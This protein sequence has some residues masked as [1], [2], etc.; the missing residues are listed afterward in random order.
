MGSG[1]DAILAELREH[2][3]AMWADEMASSKGR[4]DSIASLVRYGILRRTYVGIPGRC[5]PRVRLELIE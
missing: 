5:T 4:S 1:Q 3:R 2:G